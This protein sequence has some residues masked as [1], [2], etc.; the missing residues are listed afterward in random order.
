M[1]IAVTAWWQNY[2]PILFYFPCPLCFPN[3]L[4]GPYIALVIE[5]KL[6]TGGVTQKYGHK[7]KQ[8]IND[9]HS[10]AWRNGEWQWAPWK[11]HKL[12][13]KCTDV[14]HSLDFL[15][16]SPAPI[17]PSVTRK[18]AWKVPPQCEIHSARTYTH[19]PL[20]FLFLNT[21]DTGSHTLC[22]SERFCLAMDSFHTGG[23]GV[24]QEALGSPRRL[25]HKVNVFG[26]LI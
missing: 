16:V 11:R 9:N 1:L 14:T 3:F 7:T 26:R 8:V 19:S 6:K 21:T 10:Q 12:T 20:H 25:C 17:F 15:H 18:H 22:I 2:G 13:V 4:R 5:R 24:T 23:F